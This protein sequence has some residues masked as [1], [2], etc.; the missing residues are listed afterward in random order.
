MA[1]QQSTAGRKAG[2]LNYGIEE[3][4]YLFDIMETL[5]PIGT[6]EWNK[7]LDEHSKQYSGRTV[8]S[9]RRRYQN[10]HRKN[11][12]TGS[13]N[14]PDD[15]RQAKRIKYKIGKKAELSDG[16]EEFHLENGFKSSYE[17]EEHTNTIVDVT[18]GEPNS[19]ERNQPTVESTVQLTNNSRNTSG[20]DKTPAAA[21]P[22]SVPRDD[23]TSITPTKRSYTS[24]V[25][26]PVSSFPFPGGGDQFLQTYQMSLQQEKLSQ[27][28]EARRWE[29][30]RVEREEARERDRMQ[31]REEREDMMKM[32]G[33]AVS[34]LANAMASNNNSMSAVFRPGQTPRFEGMNGESISLPLPDEE[35]SPPPAQKRREE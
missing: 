23:N 33:I 6:E 30:E 10:L 13:P 26:T 29:R 24:R 5:L 34:Q 19:L 2:A 32:I 22:T 8:L 15:V 25:S 11:A 3:T 4:K 9:I 16:T 35:E 28:R 7:V 27:E 14:M 21:A 17:N 20:N 12:P 31:R 18:T 1:P